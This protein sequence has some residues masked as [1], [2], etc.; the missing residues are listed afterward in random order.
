MQENIPEEKPITIDELERTRTEGRD[1]LGLK[2]ILISTGLKT[3]EWYLLSKILI[4][5]IENY[6]WGDSL[7][8]LGYQNQQE[9]K[10]KILTLNSFINYEELTPL[11]YYF[12]IKCNI[13]LSDDKY[14]PKQWIKINDKKEHDKNQEEIYLLLHQGENQDIE[15]YYEAL[16][17]KKADPIKFRQRLLNEIQKLKIEEQPITSKINI[18][19]WNCNSLGSYAKRGFLI[20]QLYSQN[21]QICF[22]QETM[23][24]K[25]DK[26]FISGYKAYRADAEIRRKGTIILIS[27]ELDCLAY[28]TIQDEE[29]GRY[30]QIKLKATNKPGEIIFNNIYLEPNNHDKNIIPQEIWDSEHIIGDLN[31][32][33]TGYEKQGVYHFKNM[34][35]II[36]IIEIPKKISDHPLLILQ[37]EIPIPLKEKYETKLILDRN[38]IEWNKEKIIDITQDKNNPEFKDPKKTIKQIRHKIKLTNEDYLQDFEHMEQKEKQKFIE[39]KKRKISEINQLLNA[40]TLGREPYQRLIGLMQFNQSTKWWKPDNQKEREIVIKGFKQLY[41]HEEQKTFNIND[42]IDIMIKQLNIII[43]DQQS[44]QLG[45]PITPKSRAR[46]ANGFSQREIMEIIKGDNLNNTAQRMKYIIEKISKNETKGILIHNK[47]KQ[48]LK[49]KKDIIS[50]SNDLRGISIMPA[51]IM[52]LDKITIAYASP[53][54]DIYLSKYQHGGRSKYSTNTAKLN[55]IYSTNTK[56]YKYCLLLDLSKAFDK[57]NRQILKETINQIPDNQLSQLLLYV[58]ELY[59]KIDIDIEGEIIK[60]TRG[61]PQ[62]SAYGPLLFTLYINKILKD[63]EG[64]TDKL[65]AQAFMDD[66]IISSKDKTTLEQALNFI[67][68]EITKLDMELNLNK[69]EFLSEN[70]QDNIKD[71]TTGIILNSQQTA[72]YLG[73][74]IDANGK[75]INIINTYQFGSIS[76]IIS[77]T[78]NQIT[79]RAKIKLFSTYI[80][81]KFAH[82]I[83]MIA[84]IGNL[85]NTW[86]NIRSTIFNDILDRKTLPRETGTL[87]G[88]S[89]YSI[90]IKPILK[91][92]DKDHIKN[93]KDKY[94]FF[95]EALKSTF[96][97]WI[98]VEPNNTPNIK[99]YIDDLLSKNTL[100]TLEE[101]EEEIYIQAAARLFRNKNIPKNIKKL[102]TANLPRILEILSN[103]PEHLIEETIKQKVLNQNT[104]DEEGINKLI[105][106]YIMQYL[107]TYIIISKNYQ[108]PKIDKPNP[109]DLKQILEYEQIYDLK[110]EIILDKELENTE[111]QTKE[112]IKE[113]IESNKQ[114]H[115][116][117][118]IIPQKLQSI[119]EQVKAILPSKDKQYWI[120]LE[121][122]TEKSINRHTL[123]L[124]K[125]DKKKP[126]RPK[127][128]KNKINDSKQQILDIYINN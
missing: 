16:I 93:D 10:N 62:G 49:K 24:L 73:Q 115:N 94:D 85:E 88:I 14:K 82:L 122:L 44:N 108:I 109:E 86:K 56:G 71:Q 25:K 87:L 100:H 77:N 5:C 99:I 60:P 13:Y 111:I 30:L 89:F 52:T 66:I 57:V 103:A 33:E 123:N 121:I 76:K 78:S 105:Y 106:Q 46:D 117:I 107:L 74:T 80:K 97:T 9:L 35:K 102:T 90:I 112:I 1:I 83:P 118:P 72:K 29:N 113:V 45:P 28:K 127:Q 54:A 37:T 11:F 63:M 69:C 27:D 58:T 17:N 26:L 119:I 51:I 3:E 41:K 67:H 18:M 110:M 126:G 43:N 116:E 50:S 47:S 124:Y 59:K 70:P 120:M 98:S 6:N 53:K 125:K 68:Q 84:L 19:Q 61:I 15:G 91:I 36:Q 31:K 7:N 8:E 23:L 128:E 81:A 48:L 92:L 42:T 65:S 21:I 114:Q 104:P 40:Q 32:L 101:F 75:T 12:N 55:L 2:S 96:K 20:E 64:K 79:Q 4:K 22:L 34:G 95:K 39:L 38:I